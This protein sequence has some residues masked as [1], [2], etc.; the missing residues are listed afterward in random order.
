[1]NKEK[2]K[3]ILK[4]VLILIVQIA[5]S[6][7]QFG[8]VFPLGFPFAIVRI[9]FGGNLMLVA[10][11]YLISSLYLFLD[12]FMILFVGFEIIILSLFYFFKEMFKLKR[13]K[14]WLT[15]FL[16]LST[17]LKLYF[18]INHR[19]LWQDYLIETGLKILALFYFIKLYQI[20]QKKFIFLKCSNLDYLFFSCFIVLFILGLFGYQFL[21]N[22]FG[23]CLFVAAVVFC[24]R[25]LPSE[26]F[27]ILSLTLALCFGLVFLSYKLV[28]ISALVIVLMISFSRLNKYVFLSVM[29]FMLFMAMKISGELTLKNMIS[30]F[31]GVIIVAFIPQKFVMR[32]SKF[33]EDRSL[34]TIKE[35]VWLEK[36]SE[37]RKNLMLMSKT[38]SKMQD[39]FRF[40][41]VGKIDRKCAAT[42][43]AKDVMKRCC[44]ACEN[45]MF[46][47]NSLIDKSRLISEYVTYAIYN[48]ELATENL[49]VGFKT[50]CHKTINIVREINAISKNYLEFEANVK[51]EDESK[52][53]VSTELGNFAKLFQNFSKTIEKTPKL[54]KNI[55]L[56]TKEILKN[57]MIEVSDIGIF[58]DNSGIEKIDVVVDNGLV[59]RKELVTELSKVVK[60]KLQVKKIKHLD[61]SGMSLVTFEVANDLKADFAIASSAK[62]NVSGD[63]TLISRVDDNR[64]FIAIAD[65]MGHGKIAGK[66]SRMVLELIKNL[67]FVGIDLD[68][69]IDSVNKLLLP[70]GLDNFSTLDIA[71]VD[72]RLSKTTFI[73]LGSSVSAIKRKDRTEIVSCE[74][75]PIGIVQNLKPSVSVCPI[76]AG[77]I[78]VLASDGVVD[79][80]GEIENFKVYV[81]DSD[82]SSLQRF[83]DN[84]IFELNSM[85][86]KH[87]DDMS[88]IALKLLKNSI[89]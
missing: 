66:T 54:N 89:K 70:V 59:L 41:I 77:D 15:L 3:F 10:F 57:N 19:L 48:G 79:S 34:D 5:F 74:S 4:E 75:L 28:V 68:V 29:L 24:C 69:I 67:F 37:I 45:K 56:V 30:L 32:L 14:L 82:M 58:E 20:Y 27:L 42:E 84:T 87:K 21:T 73:K 17:M 23:L 53:L 8:Q 18:A 50:Y 2:L 64:F 51:S 16:C 26:K 13:K 65:G 47:D 62:E 80:F 9:F 11:E 7:A 52:L 55:S 43:L 81:N 78:I 76:Q 36:E 49:S 63:N 35:N 25:F 46:C 83:A 22:I 1:M 88:I 40:L 31:S 61:F 12:F 38:L 39:D 85:P 44:D 71:I 33:F 86:N 72:L 60:S 6:R